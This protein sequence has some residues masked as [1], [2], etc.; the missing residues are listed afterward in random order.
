MINQ[1]LRPRSGRSFFKSFLFVLCIAVGFAACK[2]NYTPQPDPADIS[3]SR[4]SLEARVLSVDLNFFIVSVDKA[5]DSAGVQI[6]GLRQIR[7]FGAP[8]MELCGKYLIDVKMPNDILLNPGYTGNISP[9]QLLE[10]RVLNNKADNIVDAAFCS[11]AG[12]KSRLNSVMQQSFSEDAA[13]FLMSV[14]TGYRGGFSPELRDAFSATGL[15]HLISIS[16][17]HFG[18]LF[19]VV[20]QIFKRMLGLLPYRALAAITLYA[21]P[22]QIAAALSMPVM[23]FYLGLSDMSFPAVRSFIMISFFL[24]GLLAQRRG[25]W[26]NTVLLAAVIILF[27][28]PDSLLDLSFQ[29]SFSAVFCIGLAADMLRKKEDVQDD[30]SLQDASKGFNWII[31]R[32]KKFLFSTAVISLAASAGT[33]PLVAYYFHYVSIISPLANLIVTPIAGFV[34]LP[35]ALFSSFAYLVS[36]YLPMVQIIDGITSF[37]M[38]LIKL[39]AG[40]S[41][42][43]L[44]FTAFPQA[45]LLI[46]YA[47]FITLLCAYSAGL[48]YNRPLRVKTAVVL[49]SAGMLPLVVWSAFGLFSYHGTK[50]TFLDAGQ[51][52]SAVAELPD[53]R[54]VVID[55]GRNGFQTASYL[56]YRG[57]SRIDALVISHAE[58]DHA[59]GA[60][61]LASRFM[62]NEIWD[63]GMIEYTG[64]LALI[65]RRAMLRGDFAE[66]KGYRI[67][68]LHPHA[69]FYTMSSN[70][71]GENNDSI[72]LLLDTGKNRML[73]SGDVAQEAVDDIVEL[74]DSLKADLIKVPHHGSRTA[75]DEIFYFYVSPR[76]AVISSGR[77]N[78]YGHPHPETLA[79]LDSA[80]VYR[81]DTH[82][83][84][85][86]REL[87]DGR[88]EVRRWS[89]T[90]FEPATNFDS[91]LA[92]I[93]RLFV[94]W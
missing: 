78:Q 9:V 2:T 66:G 84:V 58:S 25:I 33:A 37:C 46:F 11:F 34:V 50:I 13:A 5:H 12:M 74:G 87:G 10:A 21:T 64:N 18:L 75:A 71:S 16:G 68:A 36:G 24:A 56:R 94:V 17:T 47:S 62:I 89:D 30:E 76:I 55:T 8:D 88:L 61:Y 3:G 1:K 4:F 70:E 35:L 82:G 65:P 39:M 63:N 93:K 52:D 22:S 20:F 26:I 41:F 14:T 81:T 31:Q 40:F 85:Q 42:A 91:E 7:I 54:T 29:L 28:R 6:E 53:K 69:S 72:V 23:V 19:L 80:S 59:G 51:A 73:F 57:I 83:A 27:F 79:L 48:R 15:A 49:T 86:V 77:K 67:T 90:L 60:G 44:K 43:E 45:I 38:S 92:N 32:I